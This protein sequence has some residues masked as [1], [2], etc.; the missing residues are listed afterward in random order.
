[1]ADQV[2]LQ[3]RKNNTANDWADVGNKAGNESVPVSVPSLPLPAGAATSA[4]QTTSEDSNTLLRRVVKLLEPSG[5]RD[6]NNRQR[7]TVD[8]I[9]AGQNTIGVV[10]VN[11]AAANGGNGPGVGAPTNIA[12][13]YQAVWMGPIDQRFLYKD[14]CRLTYNQGIRSHLI[15]T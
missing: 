3:V 12:T 8:S 7:I 2:R 14:A 6:I 15:F 10:G 9:T 5:L 11:V 13:S 1:M 4:A